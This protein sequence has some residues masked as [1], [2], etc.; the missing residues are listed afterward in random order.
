ME[1]LCSLLIGPEG[2][3]GYGFIGSVAQRTMEDMQ[4]NGEYQ[5]CT[6]ETHD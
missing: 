4:Q 1:T 5:L 2:N 3:G 6:R